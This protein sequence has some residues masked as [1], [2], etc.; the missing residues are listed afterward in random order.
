MDPADGIYVFRCTCVHVDTQV[1]TRMCTYTHIV[2]YTH[3]NKEK[4]NM[5]LRGNK[6]G[7][8]IGGSRGKKRKRT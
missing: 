7:R 3:T 5:T 4:D 2:T 1:Y 8:Y 6:R